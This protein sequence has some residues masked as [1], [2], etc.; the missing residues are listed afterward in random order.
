MQRVGGT[1]ASSLK[2]DGHKRH[3]NVL[4]RFVFTRHH[5]IKVTTRACKKP[6]NSV[7]VLLQCFV[8]RHVIS[9]QSL[10]VVYGKRES[11]LPN[12]LCQRSAPTLRAAC[13]A[14]RGALGRYCC[15]AGFGQMRR[16]TPQA[17]DP[18]WCEAE[19]LSS[20]WIVG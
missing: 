7:R 4:A 18:A 14:A 19:E 8:R 10:W 9:L 15:T 20:R 13:P 16:S 2:S 17:Y 11:H 5:N 3:I 1:S 6:Y 12:L